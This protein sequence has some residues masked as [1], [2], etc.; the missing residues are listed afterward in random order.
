MVVAGTAAA[1]GGL[2]RDALTTFSLLRA[3]AVGP[4][5]S[6]GRIAMAATFGALVAAGLA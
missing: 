6:L 4:D 1:I 2:L 3:F 5:L